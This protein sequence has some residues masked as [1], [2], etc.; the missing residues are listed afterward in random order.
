MAEAWL[1]KLG[2]PRFEVT[3]A[4]FESCP[5]LPLVIEALE[6]AGL[7]L[8]APGPQPTVF[9]LYKAGRFFDH[10][11]RVC[12]EEQGQRC[13][14]FPRL[15]E[16]L[17][18]SLP[19]PTTFSGSRAQQLARIIELRDTIGRRVETWLTTLRS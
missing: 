19:D 16:H 18:W 2:G 14:L 12:D 15:R 13:P 8:D 5:T 9:E 3:S 10:V 17:S 7:N 1:R 4:G 6:K 11:I